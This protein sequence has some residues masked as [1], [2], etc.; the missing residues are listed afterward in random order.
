MIIWGNRRWKSVSGGSNIK[1]LKPHG[2]KS[3]DYV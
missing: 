2:G 1:A 3:M